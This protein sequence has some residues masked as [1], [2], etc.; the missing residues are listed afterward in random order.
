MS[1]EK[2]NWT[3]RHIGQWVQAVIF[4]LDGVVTDTA[5]SHARAWKQ[6]FDDYLETLNQQK[7]RP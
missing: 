7:G 4:D 3:T 5:E 1:N 2:T 6:M